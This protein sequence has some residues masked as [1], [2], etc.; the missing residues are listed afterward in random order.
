MY[1]RE[2]ICQL[3][4]SRKLKISKKLIKTNEQI[5]LDSSAREEHD[6]F[7]LLIVEKIVKAP[8][9]TVLAKWIGGQVRIVR[10]NITILQRDFI[11]DGRPQGRS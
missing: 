4:Y 3:N 2:I 9:T 1:Y 7:Q 6:S 10:V 11:V 8:Q 5:L